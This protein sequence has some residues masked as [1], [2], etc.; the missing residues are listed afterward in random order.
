MNDYDYK[1]QQ[2]E[3]SDVSSQYDFHSISDKAIEALDPYYSNFD[4]PV[5]NIKNQKQSTTRL[6][7]RV[8]EYQTNSNCLKTEVRKKPTEVKPIPLTSAKTMKQKRTVKRMTLDFSE[9]LSLSFVSPLKSHKSKNTLGE[10]S[11][12]SPT[13][14]RM[15][16]ELTHEL[17][18]LNKEISEKL[19]LVRS[20]EKLCEEEEMIQLD[21]LSQVGNIFALL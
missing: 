4:K 17:T 5:T 13:T 6:Q 11:P 8:S 1:N 12:E 10:E 15:N 16:R 21:L 19:N 20:L 9:L 18:K 14:S 3:L 7:V 2:T